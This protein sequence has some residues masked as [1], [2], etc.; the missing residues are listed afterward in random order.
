MTLAPV[1]MN[2]S[3]ADLNEYVKNMTAGAKGSDL[4]TGLWYVGVIMSIIASISSNLGVNV[5]KYSMIKEHERCV[6]SKDHVFRPFVKQGWW[7]IGLL[8]VILGSLGDFA[9]LGFAAQSLATPVG[10]FTMVANLFFAKFFLKEKLGCRDVFATLAIVLGVV[11]VAVSADK[12]EKTYTLDCLIDLYATLRFQIY[13]ASV[14]FLCLV[15]YYFTKKLTKMRCQCKRLRKG[16]SYWKWRKLH[17]I[18]P[19]ALS[20]VAGAQSVLF[21]KCTAELIKK[22]IEGESQFTSY[23]TYLIIVAMF[24]CV[25]TQLH[26]LAVG[27]KDF[28]ATLIVPVFQCFFIT[29]GIVAGGVFFDE[30]SYLKDW[31]LGTFA[32]GVSLTLFGVY[33]LAQR[34]QK[35][36]DSA[37]T[38]D[39]FRSTARTSSAVVPET[40]PVQTIG[41]S[42]EE[43]SDS[44]NNSYS[45]YYTDPDF[46]GQRFDR[47]PTP[48]PM[49]IQYH[50]LAMRDLYHAIREG[51]STPERRAARSRMRRNTAPAHAL[52]SVPENTPV[53][54]DESSRRI[55]KDPEEKKEKNKK[56][57]DKKKKKKRGEKKKKKED[58]AGSAA[59]DKDGKGK[60]KKKKKAEISEVTAVTKFLDDDDAGEEKGDENKVV[61]NGKSSKKP[62]K[63]RR[64]TTGGID[65]HDAEK[66]EGGEACAAPGRSKK[67]KKKKKKKDKKRKRS[68]SEDGASSE[69]EPPT[70]N[71]ATSSKGRAWTKE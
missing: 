47:P 45:S 17:P 62:L 57:K 69:S 2:L 55:K 64:S 42:S 20:G 35:F 54:P 38:N 36:E 7:L 31:E 65:V 50:S 4:L 46:P 9:A 22:S 39:L 61:E 6:K 26:F 37:S 10:G 70:P 48:M 13:I 67:K 59:P 12:T 32:G 52:G 30:F 71:D 3:K 63:Q 21:A 40:T 51:L 44:L 33:L 49:S 19:S 11:A 18:F 15:L 58:G 41:Q 29:C 60:K 8:L 14:A 16:E 28:D 68:A 24:V 66:T 27:L 5:Q 34:E 43:D 25:F 56:K 23:E 53:T 1:C